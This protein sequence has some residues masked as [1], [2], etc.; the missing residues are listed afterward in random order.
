M[1]ACLRS[2]AR[3]R[4]Y[5]ITIFVLSFVVQMVARFFFC[6]PSLLYPIPRLSPSLAAICSLCFN[7]FSL[8][9]VIG[10]VVVA[11]AVAVGC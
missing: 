3:L 6:V 2:F 7:F 4:N 9:I 11:V 10:A 8:V 5:I 1:C